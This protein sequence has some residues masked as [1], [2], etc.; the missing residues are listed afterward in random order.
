MKKIFLFSLLFITTNVV[1]ATPWWEQPTVCR[2]N[3][4]TCYT[5][6]GT[7]Y[8]AGLWDAWANC[9][10]MK[11]ICGEA[12]KY[13][14]ETM[15]VGRTELSRGTL[16]NSDYDL[17]V[18][19]GDCFGVRKTSTDGSMASVNGQMVRVWCSGILDQVDEVI[20]NGEITYGTQPDCQTLADA[21]Y[22]AVGNGK[23][24]GKYYDPARYYIQ[25][26]GETPTLIVLNGANYEMGYTS[27]PAT[28]ED[29]DAIFNSMYANVHGTA[30]IPQ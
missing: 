10:G 1:A 28:Q 17:S 20:E 4:A 26:A 19:N 27:Y 30:Q 13:S 3:P 7:G 5:S 8:D 15:P 23:C 29:A 18:L 22:V 25:C 12:L 6:M 9:W 24:Y 16:T 14:D 2:V 21:G 11:M